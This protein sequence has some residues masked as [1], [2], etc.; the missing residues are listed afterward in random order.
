MGAGFRVNGVTTLTHGSVA[1]K[2]T[3]TATGP[4]SVVLHANTTAVGNVGAGEDDLMT[5]SLPANTLSANGKGVRITAC[6]TY[7]ANGN[8]KTI[9][10]YFGSTVLVT[11]SA[12]DNGSFIKL[13]GYVTRTGASTQEASGFLYFT[14]G[15][16]L[17]RSTP[18][19]DTT[20]AITIKMTGEATSND[21]IVQRVL[22]VEALN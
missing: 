18:A 5:Y 10:L 14:N 9:K 1:Q 4:V 11:R 21:D 6:V 20:G 3:G 15:S 22:I 2:G 13:E 16:A 8:T 19:E 7:A 12:G 17:T